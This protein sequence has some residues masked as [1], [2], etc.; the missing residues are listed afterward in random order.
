M[1]RQII[2]LLLAGVLAGCNSTRPA[3]PCEP[4]V[5]PKPY[6]VPFYVGVLIP[7]LSPMEL[8]AYPSPPPPGA[9]EEEYKDYAH[10]IGEVTKERAAIRDARIR[11]LQMQI[12]ANNDFA[13]EHPAPEASPTPPPE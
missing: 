9:S 8:P 13:K 10:R 11:A 2:I 4:E 12:E 7:P 6:P 3:P 5:V 1:R